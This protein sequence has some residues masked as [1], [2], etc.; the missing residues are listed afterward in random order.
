VCGYRD[1]N[2]VV[3]RAQQLRVSLARGSAASSPAAA[4]GA[5]LLGDYR[6][7]AVATP[8]APLPPPSAAAVE[9]AVAAGD[10]LPRA[11]APALLRAGSSGKRNADA[12]AMLARACG[13]LLRLPEGSVTSPE[14]VLLRLCMQ[15]TS[16]EAP[17]KSS[18]SVLLSVISIL[19]ASSGR[20]L[21]A[22]L[23]RC[24]GR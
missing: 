22:A 1:L 18:V 7:I 3:T 15:R 19:A 4:R 12:E 9:R 17:W 23:A 11:L 2:A 6:H 16:I 24:G 13:E 5:A 10:F 8:P 14:L 21:A 20:R